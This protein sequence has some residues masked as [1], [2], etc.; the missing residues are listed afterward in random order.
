MQIKTRLSSLLFSCVVLAVSLSVGW[1]EEKPNTPEILLKLAEV[2]KKLELEPWQKVLFEEEVV[3]HYQKFQVGIDLD[4]IKRYLMFYAPKILK[5]KDPKILILLKADPTCT[6]C[7]DSVSAIRELV[8]LR[9]ERRGLTPIW[10]SADDFGPAS[11]LVPFEDQMVAMVKQKNVAGALVVQWAPA[12]IEEIDTAH[13][14]EKK[15]IIHSFLR[16][17]ENSFRNR[18]KELMDTDSFEVV[19]ARLLTDLFTDLGARIEW[20]QAN[21]AENSKE[22]VLI[23][24]SGIKDFAQYSRIKTKLQTQLKDVTAIED[25]KLSR[26]QIVF[27]VYT[28]KKVD[29]VRADLA[30]I[31]LDSAGGQ[32]LTVVVR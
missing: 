4:S 14:D 2:Q 29:E 19:E 17:G 6:K 31:E 9:V 7:N 23:E 21:L 11:T 16:I 3:P 25:R 12:P 24:V 26:D 8:R 1:A 22:E 27:A 13:A 15:Y 20:E 30:T 32:L 28:K 5:Q 10:L 18:Q